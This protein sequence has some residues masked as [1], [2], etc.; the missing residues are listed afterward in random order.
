LKA[1]VALIAVV[2]VGGGDGAAS[3][4]AAGGGEDAASARDGGSAG[5]SICLLK[6]SA[7]P[8][9]LKGLVDEAVPSGPLSRCLGGSPPCTG[10]ILEGPDVGAW[11]DFNDV[12][13]ASVPLTG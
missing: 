1:S 5:A 10:F 2:G 12:P 3:G 8:G 9:D 7:S 6:S 11:A 4:P 13:G